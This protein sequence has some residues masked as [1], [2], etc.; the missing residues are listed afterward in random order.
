MDSPEVATVCVLTFSSRALWVAQSFI[1]DLLPQVLCFEVMYVLPAH[2]PELNHLTLTA[3]LIILTPTPS[4]H[5]PPSTLTP[6]LPLPKPPPPHS[7]LF[8]MLEG[9]PVPYEPFLQKIRHALVNVP[10]LIVQRICRDSLMLGDL[11]RFA[12]DETIRKRQERRTFSEDTWLQIAAG[13][14]WDSH[15]G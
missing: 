8:I 2:P 7:W 10:N 3:T 4:S 5:P 14:R 11:I 15:G 13:G 1:A 12:V 9:Y 6:I